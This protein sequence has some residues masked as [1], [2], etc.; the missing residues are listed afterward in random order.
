MQRYDFDLIVIGAGSG[1]VRAS[2]FASLNHGKRV[3]IV[4]NRRT[5][6]TCVMRGC[7]PKKLLVYGSS[8]SHDID[9]SKGY[10]WSIESANHSWSDLIDAKNRELGRLERIYHKLLADAGVREFNGTGKLADQHTVEVNGQTITSEHILIAT[11]GTPSIPKI[12]GMN[13]SITSDDALDLSE[14]PERIVIV[15][16]GYIAVEFSGI[17]NNLGVNV[18]KIVRADQILRGFDNTIRTTLGQEMKNQGIQIHSQKTV[19]EVKK[20]E[21]GYSIKIG[22]NEILQTDKIMCATGRIPNTSNIG[23]KE[24]GV[25]LDEKGAITVNKYS[26]TKVENIFAIGDATNRVTL[27]PVALEEA[28]SVVDTLY[29]PKRRAVSYENI[30]SAVFSSPPIGTVG[31]TE[32]HALR[33][34]DIDIF[35]SRFQPMKYSLSRRNENSL[36]K[37]I[38]DKATDRVLGAH[39]I[40]LDAPEIIQGIAI[41]IKSGATKAHF[42][43]TLGIHPTSAEEFVT[44]RTPSS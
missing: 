1:G 12:P 15:G 3:A 38:V 8:F 29:G 31:L 36:V 20:L 14:L 17:F 16:G 27:T 42:D 21:N 24:N 18:H 32:E 4:E 43:S 13:E 10:G 44:M 7:V 22:S 37:L 11:G 40:G 34:H 23:L 19:R 28:M 30:P 9:N 39:M 2:R 35:L 41:A 5:G 33:E 26:M 25:E 6:G